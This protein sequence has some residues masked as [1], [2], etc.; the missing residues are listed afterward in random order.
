M[1]RPIFFF[2]QANDSDDSDDSDEDSSSSSSVSTSDDTDNEEEHVNKVQVT[3]STHVGDTQNMVP[4]VDTQGM[5]DAKNIETG[6]I[7]DTTDA[8]DIEGARDLDEQGQTLDNTPDIEGAHDIEGFENFIYPRNLEPRGGTCENKTFDEFEGSV[9]CAGDDTPDKKRVKLDA[10]QQLEKA[11]SNGLGGDGGTP[12]VAPDINEGVVM[13][14]SESVAMEEDFGVTAG[15]VYGPGLVI[16]CQAGDS[17]HD[18][19]GFPQLDG[20]GDGSEDEDDEPASKMARTDLDN[21]AEPS[22]KITRD[23]IYSAKKYACV[24]KGCSYA[25]G[26]QNLLEEHSIKS[27]RGK[28]SSA[29]VPVNDNKPGY[30]RLCDWSGCNRAFPNTYGL[31]KH[32]VEVHAAGENY[33]QGCLWKDCRR[34][35]STWKARAP[36]SY[37]TPLPPSPPS[38]LLRTYCFFTTFHSSLCHINT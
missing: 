34:T 12:H 18:R 29:F 9:V 32:L 30:L 36:I 24:R 1:F 21:E 33:E 15:G 17:I 11:A 23:V 10:S 35:T 2:I 8:Q 7:Q 19:S 22:A 25:F 37:I 26:S 27:C 16:G 4:V 31:G 14:E 5:D 3:H 38:L 6:V 13:R 28:G 20:F